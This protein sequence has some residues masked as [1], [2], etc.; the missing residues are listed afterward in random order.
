MKKILMIS[1]LLFGF[2]AAGTVLAAT[3]QGFVQVVN[4]GNTGLMNARFNVATNPEAGHEGS[5]FYTVTYKEN[6]SVAFAGYDSVNNISFFCSFFSS[7][8]YFET[9]V[10]MA[11]T[12]GYGTMIQVLRTG[13]SCDGLTKTQSSLAQ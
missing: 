8:P 6:T 3:Q 1:V 10:S 4:N 11:H 5:Y 9:A 12:T 2:H 13:F 7:S